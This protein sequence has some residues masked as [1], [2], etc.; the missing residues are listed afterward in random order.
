MASSPNPQLSKTALSTIFHLSLH[1]QN[2]CRLLSKPAPLLNLLL[3]VLKSENE[4][5]IRLSAATLW[6]LAANSQ[7]TK[8]LL[9]SAGSSD[10]VQQAIQHCER[11]EIL[12][13]LQRTLSV[14]SEK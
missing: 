8:I 9:R 1:P 13:T 3:T 2:R 10:A 5:S 12:S 4:D 7:K 14:I 11:P 6:A